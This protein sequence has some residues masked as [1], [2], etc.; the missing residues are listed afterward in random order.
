[1]N[2]PL[3]N[4][5]LHSPSL[6]LAQRMIFTILLN[7]ADAR[8]ISWPSQETIALQAGCSS[9]SVRGHLTKLEQ[10]G[11]IT[12]RPSQGRYN[13]YTVHTP[14]PSAVDTSAAVPPRNMLPLSAD[15]PRNRLPVTQEDS[16]STPETASADPG[17]S[18]LLTTHESINTL[19]LNHPPGADKPPGGEAREGNKKGKGEWRCW[20]SRLAE[21]ANA[22]PLTDLSPEEFK[23][24]WRRWCGYRTRKATEARIPGEAQP[25]TEDNAAATLLACQRQAVLRGWPAVIARIDEAIAGGWRSMNFDRMRDSVSGAPMA[26][27][28][29]S[30]EQKTVASWVFR[31]LDMPWSP[32]EWLLWDAIP[33]PI[34]PEVWSKLKHRY[35]QSNSPYLKRSLAA[36]LQDWNQ[37]FDH[38]NTEA[39]AA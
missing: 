36:L 22:I 5:A 20:N 27:R 10:L 6:S 30:A 19:P 35:E 25:W 28:E 29:L 2:F 3:L 33:K 7:H 26:P 8:G 32:R 14:V 34:H 31:P 38:A 12:V 16:S 17:K 23:E 15:E 18:F 9:R 4:A 1:M 11:W 21:K 39:S 13:V 37:E 24:A